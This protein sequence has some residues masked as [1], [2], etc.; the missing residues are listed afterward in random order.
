[1]HALASHMG[2]TMGNR[3]LARETSMKL[4]CDMLR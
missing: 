3:K 1:L 2:E 4:M